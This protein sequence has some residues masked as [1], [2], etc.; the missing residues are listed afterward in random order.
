MKVQ[1]PD[2]AIE[3]YE[4]VLKKNP[5]DASLSR[6]I[7][8]VLVVT[9]N[10]SKAINYYETALKNQKESQLLHDLAELYFKLKYYD[11]AIRVLTEALAEHRQHKV[12]ELSSAIE[13]SNLLILLARVH[14]YNE[15]QDD[16]LNTWRR[17]H[18][19]ID[20]FDFKLTNRFAWLCWA[21]CGYSI[22]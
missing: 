22:R 1:N 16:A 9:H 13:E 6:K 19:V 17:V 7:G 11:K 10:Y 3:V 15:Q 18:E 21:A 20:M 2:K 14:V 12:Q 5:K 4:S 8:Q